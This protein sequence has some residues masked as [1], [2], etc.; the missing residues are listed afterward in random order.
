VASKD[1]SELS[2]LSSSELSFRDSKKAFNISF[3][4]LEDFFFKEPKEAVGEVAATISYLGMRGGR[5]ALGVKSSGEVLGSK[6]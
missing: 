1:A 6:V 4:F 2:F 5:K 3:F